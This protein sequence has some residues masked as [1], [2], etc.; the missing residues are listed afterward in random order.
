MMNTIPVPLTEAEVVKL[1][2]LVKIGRFKNR[3]QA[4]L[5]ILRIGIQ[6][7]MIPLKGK[8]WMKKII[9]LN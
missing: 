8:D 6:S 9:V 1:D 7:Q 5:T 3:T 4:I 2:Y